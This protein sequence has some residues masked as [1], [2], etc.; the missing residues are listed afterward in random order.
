MKVDTSRH[1]SVQTYFWQTVG[2]SLASTTRNDRDATL[3]LQHMSGFVN[4]TA[5]LV[6]PLCDSGTGPKDLTNHAR[7]C[8]GFYLQ[9]SLYASN[10]HSIKLPDSPI[11]D[12]QIFCTFRPFHH[13]ISMS[14]MNCVLVRSLALKDS[15][16]RRSSA[17]G[18]Q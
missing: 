16:R 13:T 15:M 3:V 14:S 7:P 10:M 9:V 6:V 12:S 17:V 11:L 2:A 18:N 1:L 8:L 4:R 5:D